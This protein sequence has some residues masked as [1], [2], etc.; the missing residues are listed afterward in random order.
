MNKNLFKSVMLIAIAGLIYKTSLRISDKIADG[1]KDFIMLW[2]VAEVVLLLVTAI[3]VI[4]GHRWAPIALIFLASVEYLF[5]G[6]L[7]VLGVFVLGVGS[8]M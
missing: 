6:L 2:L 3:G 4:L 8:I 5:W 7:V 1:S